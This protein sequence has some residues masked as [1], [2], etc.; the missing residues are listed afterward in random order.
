M[1]TKTKLCCKCK[2]EKGLDCYGK[3]KSSKD[4]LR[5]DCNE[6]RK[7]YRLRSK[8]H[9]SNKNKQYF[10]DNKDKLIPKN[11][12]YREN[13]KESIFAQRKEYRQR[14]QQH[15]KQ[16]REDYK[17]RRAYKVRMRRQTDVSFRLEQNMRRRMH[18]AL[19]SMS[20]S[21]T[22]IIQMQCNVETLKK[23]LEFQFEDGMTWQNMGTFWEVDHI[24]PVA[25]F[26][27]T[28]QLDIS[29][30]FSWT[31]L[32][33]L[34]KEENLKKWH[35][36]QLHYYFNS[37]VS[38]HRFIQLNKTETCGYQSVNKSLH[39]L[40]QKLRYGQNPNE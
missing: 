2:Q 27:L 36:L 9:I 8:E 39:W 29:V 25:A 23:W 32:Q 6:C 16:K 1:D 7:E 19:K 3:L 34:R 31:N 38:V 24:L 5:Y 33:P 28:N 17:P 11:K 37:I 20:M 35:Y 22:M 18:T 14:N 10:A 12:Q 26:D 21:K 4:G 30:C 13:N 40:R 15:I